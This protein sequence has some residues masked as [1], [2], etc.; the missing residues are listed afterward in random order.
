MRTNLPPEGGFSRAGYQ[1]RLN[2]NT[3]LG[4]FTN[5]LRFDGRVQFSSKRQMA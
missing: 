3:S 4:D 5:R 2:G 1:I